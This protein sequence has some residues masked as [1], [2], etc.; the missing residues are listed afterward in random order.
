MSQTLSNGLIAGS[1]MGGPLGCLILKNDLLKTAVP[2]E[3]TLPVKDE[4]H[5]VVAGPLSGPI[6]GCASAA[7]QMPSP[8]ASAGSR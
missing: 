5:G 1:L 3:D 2:V 4:E 8:W 6:E 7:Y